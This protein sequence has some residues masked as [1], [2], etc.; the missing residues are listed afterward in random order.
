MQA[1]FDCVGCFF[2]QA[3]EFSRISGAG[4][5]ARTEIIN[6]TFAIL[7]E[8]SRRSSPPKYGRLIYRLA[9]KC[10]RRKDIFAHI[11]QRS[12]RFALRLYPKLK[13]KVDAAGDPLLA[14]LKLAAAGN[15]IDYGTQ[16]RF[17]AKHELDNFLKMKFAIFDYL[18]FKRELKKAGWILYLADNAGEIV[19]DRALIEKLQKPVTVAVRSRPIINDATLAD[20]KFCGLDRIARVIRSGAD[21]PGTLLEHCSAEFRKL[22]VRAPLVISKGQGNYEALE[23]CGRNV[24]YLFKVKCDVVAAYTACRSGSMIF[25]SERKA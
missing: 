9:E 6:G 14:A 8:F 23:G 16:H 3:C 24:F 7:E 2:K 19:F 11:K 15:V 22:F 20:A 5:R 25:K 18:R 1:A 13:Q 21:T 17:D 4:P 12:N 10:S